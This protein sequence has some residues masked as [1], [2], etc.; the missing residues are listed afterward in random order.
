MAKNNN[1]I[2]NNSAQV[3]LEEK[4]RL[5]ATRIFLI[6]FA[7]VALVGVLTSLVFALIPTFK[8]EKTLDYIKDNL[9][10][11]VSVPSELYNG[12]NVTVELPTVSDKD[13][14]Y[15]ILEL[16]CTHKITGDDAVVNLPGV[17]VGAG[18]IANI[19][20]R[21]YTLGEDGS[22]NY[23]DG[24]CNFT[25]SVYSLEIG[26]GTFIPGFEYN[27]VGKNQKDYATMT[28]VT[29]GKVEDGDL[30]YLTYSVYYADG[31]A[32][33][34]K[35][36]LVDL[37]DPKLDE[38]WGVGFKAYFSAVNEKTIGTQFATG[39]SDDAK[40]TVKTIKN[41]DGDDIYF[42]MSISSAYR[43]SK[44]VEPLVVEAYFPYNYGDESLDGKTAYFEVYIKSVKDYSVPE[45]NDEFITE[46]VKM[47]ADD[48]AK[49]EGATL[50][51]KY[52]AYVRELLEEQYKEDVRNVI[53]SQFWKTVIAGSTFYKL[54]EKE[55]QAAYNNYIYEIESTY[56]SGYA[57]YYG[58]L[59]EFARA[60]LELGT[61]ADWK[62]TLRQDAE[63][64]LKQKLVFYYIIRAE[65]LLP[66]DEEYQVLYDELF[67]EY[68][69]EYLDYYGITESSDNYEL[70]VENAK[71]E[72]LSTYGESYWRESV[73]YEFA[74]DAILD[75]ANVIYAN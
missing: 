70:K 61:G 53:E 55:V 39:N 23:F 8:K 65:K 58:S 63:Y 14:E 74:I 40:L 68:L 67:A 57:S 32:S 19:Y 45:F 49:Y 71:K 56:A 60:Y 10:K 29:N 47:T 34:S 2:E 48:L 52:K 26:S 73:Y 44:D 13:V 69:Q 72:I 36:T 30:I 54:P 64:S 24:G 3:E 18:D 16:L 31:Q 42:D 43:I 20:Y 28:K 11:Y 38:K 27:L 1:N 37:S 46:K 21:G 6:V 41:T 4:K 7:A 17:T 75:K 25:D 15:E 59:D 62:A 66:T 12:Y 50:T 51:E 5:D 33:L 9:S 35:T 22:K